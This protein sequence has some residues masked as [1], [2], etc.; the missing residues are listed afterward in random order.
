MI[1]RQ[2]AALAIRQPRRFGWWRRR[3]ASCEGTPWRRLTATADQA[4]G[5]TLRRCLARWAETGLLGKVHI[6]LVSMLRGHPDLI[7]DT[8]SVRAKRGGD[9][10]GPNPIDRGKQGTKYHIATAS[11]A[12]SMQ[13]LAQVMV[14]AAQGQMTYQLSR[15]DQDGMINRTSDQDIEQAWANSCAMVAQAGGT[16]NQCTAA[17]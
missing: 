4:S 12:Q 5:A 8:C 10:T 17:Q 15:Q 1:G 2:A 13:K 9:L 7:L 16:S 3:A 11:M 6:L 14:T